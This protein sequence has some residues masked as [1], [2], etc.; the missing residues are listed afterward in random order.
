MIFTNSIFSWN[1][2]KNSQGETGRIV[3]FFAKR[4]L[5]IMATS[6]FQWPTPR[7]KYRI[8]IP[9]ALLQTEIQV[10]MFVHEQTVNFHKQSIMLKYRQVE[11]QG[12]FSFSRC[13]NGWHFKIRSPQ[14]VL[15]LRIYHQDS[16]D[17]CYCFCFQLFAWNQ[18]VCLTN[19]KTAIFLEWWIL[20]SYLAL[21]LDTKL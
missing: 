9:W 16:D 6:C 15:M 3:I 14:W 12:M 2:R 19:F 5:W 1:L 21:A 7:Y 11:G 17:F 18:H 10:A 8:W 13:A 4:V 20:L